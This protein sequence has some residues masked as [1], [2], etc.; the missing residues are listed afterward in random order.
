M[1]P[2]WID[3]QACGSLSREEAR[4]R[5]G[6]TRRLAVSVIGQLTT[7]KRQDLFIRAAAYLIKEKL[8]FDVDF[9]IVGAAARSDEQYE[10]KL[11]ALV[12]E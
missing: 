6:I 9:L 12:N 7:L 5:L 3:S 1:I 8:W 11:H 4:Q 10:R 2:N